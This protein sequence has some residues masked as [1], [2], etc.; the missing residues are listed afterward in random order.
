MSLSIAVIVG[1]LRRESINRR[2]AEAITR[3]PAAADHRFAFS[4]IGD[5]PLYNQ[6]DDAAPPAPAVRLKT[7][8]TA[9]DAVL[10]VTPEYNRSIPG[11]LKNALDHASRPYGQSAW[12]KKP[13]GVIGTSQG[14]I[15]TALAQHHLRSVL[16]YLDM[17]V[18]DQPEAYIRFT[19]DLI[20]ADGRLAGGTADFIAA[21]LHAFIAHAQ[22]HR[23]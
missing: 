21:W 1:S 18:L 12:A 6:D 14:Q 4:E 7:E 22:Q 10:F 3:L 19:D 17:P 8:V 2:L 16:A 5:L 13:A 20:D 15:G 9:A 11:V 23:A